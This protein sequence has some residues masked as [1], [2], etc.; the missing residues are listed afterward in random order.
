MDID[1]IARAQLLEGIEALAGARSI[2]AVV[3]V[4]RRYARDIAGADG[5]CVILRDGDLCHYAAEDATGPLWTG[6]RFP[7]ATCVSGWVMLNRQAAMI[8]DIYGDDR[9]PHDAYRPTF[10]RSMLMTPVGSPEVTAAIGA[11]WAET[12]TPQPATIE[13]LET[14]ARAAA[15]AF[16]SAKLLDALTISERRF[17]G[18]ADSI[19]QMI[20]S[21]RPDGFHDYYNKRWYD[22]TG[23]PSGSTD[24]EAWNGMFHAEDQERAW[25]RWRHSLETGDVY[26]IE[27]R[28]RHWSGEYRWVLGRAWPVR[29]DHGVIT[30]WYGTCTDINELRMAQDDLRELNASLES[31]VAERTTELQ[32]QIDERERMETT[33]R[34]MQRLEAV[35]QLTS[36]VAHDFNNLLTVILGNLEFLQ[37]DAGQTADPKFGR[38]VAN[39]KQAAE[40]GAKLTAQLLAFSRRQRLEAKPIDLNDTVSSMQD[41]LRSSMGG[42]VGI[43]LVLHPQLWSA[44]VDQTQLELVILNLAINARDAMQVGGALAIETANATVGPPQ[45]PEEPA[46]G[47][48]VVVSVADTGSG[49]SEAVLARAFEPFFTTKEVG[50]GSGLGLAQVYGFAKQSGGGVRIE[51]RVGEGTVVKVYLPRVIDA[52]PALAVDDGAMLDLVPGSTRVLVIDDDSAVREITVSLLQQMGCSVEDAGSGGA[53]LDLLARSEAA[54]DLV[55]LD[56]AMPGMNGAEVAREI[57][58][59]F[60]ELPVL[61]VTGYADLTA[62][63]EVGEDRIAQKPFDHAEFAAK[64]KRLLGVEAGSSNVV[65]MRR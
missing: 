23:M 1:H 51:T 63:R 24:G 32:R 45:R 10:V 56:F 13:R 16:E 9:V 61:F 15:I 34:Q 37:R 43:E 64:V 30:R 17:E 19:D 4:L 31:R 5:I 58:K 59:D 54:F 50:K 2:D 53:G 20:W 60:P 62:L 21:T 3:D 22:Y 41:L 25:A 18:I 39:M 26:E 49:M 28:L 12:L 8:P 14:L 36:G 35:G 33:L 42:S 40:R 47:D 7:M 6:Q 65:A 57:A 11:Y 55:V 48:Y 52:S 38:R 46:A 44:L 29:D 27:Y